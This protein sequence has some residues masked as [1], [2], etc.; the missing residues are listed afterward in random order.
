MT[1]E[2]WVE[3]YVKHPED[4]LMFIKIANSQAKLIAQYIRE[5]EGKWTHEE[6]K[7][8]ESKK[9]EYPPNIPNGFGIRRKDDV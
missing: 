4:L 1:D 9:V 2:E 3:Y 5:L 7:N 8:E 6:S